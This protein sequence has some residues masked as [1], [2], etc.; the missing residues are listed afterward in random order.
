MDAGFHIIQISSLSQ[1]HSPKLN[2]ASVA[3]ISFSISAG[4]IGTMYSTYIYNEMEYTAW[5]IF[6]GMCSCP[7]L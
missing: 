4:V 6:L 1:T 2:L 5:C 7:L 3:S